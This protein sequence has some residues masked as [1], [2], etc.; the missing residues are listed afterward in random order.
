MVNVMSLQEDHYFQC[1]ESGHI[2]HHCPNVQCFKCDEYGHILMDCPHRVIIGTD[3]VGLDHNAI[4]TDIT[5]KV[6]RTP[7]E[8]IPGHTTGI[9]DDIT[10]VVHD[11]HSQVLIHIILT[12]TLHITGHL[13]TEAL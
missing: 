12:T 10:G 11:A 7:T 5:A 13:P 3:T 2:V 6:I 1:Q 9:T 8:A 4:L